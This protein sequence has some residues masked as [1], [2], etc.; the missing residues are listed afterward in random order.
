M[1]MNEL[2]RRMA[3][4]VRALKGQTRIEPLAVPA[5]E[6][7]RQPVQTFQVKYEISLDELGRRGPGFEA[8]WIM[9]EM[10]ARL[11]KQMEASGLVQHRADRFGGHIIYTAKIRVIGPCEEDRHV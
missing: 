3:N 5:L 2:K 10:R 11:L 8:H 7:E 4:A 9:P 1:K 6:V